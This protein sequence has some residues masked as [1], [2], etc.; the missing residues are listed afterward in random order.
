M[1]CPNS[2]DFRD[3]LSGRSTHGTNAKCQLRQA[4]S[5][6]MGTA[7]DIYSYRVLPSLTQ[8]APIEIEKELNLDGTEGLRRARLRP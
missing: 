1:V 4:M 3:V 2:M 6:F 5:K 8:F 7:E